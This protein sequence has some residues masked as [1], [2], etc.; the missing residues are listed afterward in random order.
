MDIKITINTDNEA[1]SN[2]PG[3]EIAR[4]LRRLARE[5]ED[6]RGKQD[7]GCNLRDIN[8]NKVGKL[9]ITK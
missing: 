3:G 4:I 9:E 1:F 7:I 2:C 8:G 5:I 6:W